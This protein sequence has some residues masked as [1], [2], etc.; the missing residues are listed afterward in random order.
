MATPVQ[1]HADDLIDPLTNFKFNIDELLAR[2]KISLRGV[3]KFYF[4]WV[5]LIFIHISLF[6]F[7]PILGNRKYNGV[8]YC[9][10]GSD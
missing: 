6:F 2:S 5:F 1:N 7:L 4:Q 9:D 10:K 3:L 8:G